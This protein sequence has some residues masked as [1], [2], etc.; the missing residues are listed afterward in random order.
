MP[1]P[2]AR[3]LLGGGGRRA[4]AGAL[5]AAAAATVVIA[6]D[7]IFGPATHVGRSLRG[8]PG[9]IASDIADRLALSWARATA[10][11]AVAVVVA[12]S[13]VALAV[14]VARLRNVRLE[15]EGRAVLA[16]FAVAIAVSL[17]VND[18]PREV[19][20]GGLVGYLALERWVRGPVTTRLGARIGIPL[21]R[22]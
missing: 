18:S 17:L 16:A 21:P 22:S 9:E 11:P 5:A 14:L 10:S 15:R 6:L 1:R 2:R 19:A 8:G 4:W 3:D 12:A 7:A 13:I 20:V